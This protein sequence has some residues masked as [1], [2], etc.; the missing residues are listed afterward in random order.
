MF[1][2]HCSFFNMFS[3]LQNSYLTVELSFAEP[4]IDIAIIL[5]ETREERTFRNWMNSLGVN[6]RVNHLYR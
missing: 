6:P 3:F 5:G 2:V 1:S 4:L